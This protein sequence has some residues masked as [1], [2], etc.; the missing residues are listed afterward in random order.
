SPQEGLDLVLGDE[1]DS[2]MSQK[3]ALIV[4]THRD[5][6]LVLRARLALARL[7]LADD[8][9][10]GTQALAMSREKQYDLALVDASAGG[11]VDAWALLRQLRTGRHA[12]P[13]VAITKPGLSLLERLRA[14]MSGVEALLD[15]PP[16]AQ[17]ETWL[18]RI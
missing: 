10:S 17:F 2:V 9:D 6:R 13:H 3:Q 14:R 5:V 18:S 15:P 8:A 4:S 11:E 16:P 12:V 1:P 7:T